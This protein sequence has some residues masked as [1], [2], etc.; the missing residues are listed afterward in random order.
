[1]SLNLSENDL[2]HFHN[3]QCCLALTKYYFYICNVDQ[4]QCSPVQ[5]LNDSLLIRSIDR[6]KIEMR[7]R[8]SG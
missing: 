8:T 7:G 4:K 5:G 1:M 6:N 2:I 3:V